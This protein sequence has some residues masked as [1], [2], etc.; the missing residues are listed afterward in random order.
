MIFISLVL[1]GVTS[2][3]IEVISYPFFFI[4]LFSVSG[5]SFKCSSVTKGDEHKLLLS[6]TFIYA[7]SH[8]LRMRTRR[9]MV[10]DVGGVNSHRVKN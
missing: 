8:M 4:V 10:L 5:V 6:E 2:Q 7:P 3:I 1:I 9:E